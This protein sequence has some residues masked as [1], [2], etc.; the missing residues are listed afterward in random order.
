MRRHVLFFASFVGA[1]AVGA[2]SGCGDPPKSRQEITGEVIL[3]GQP[4][5]DGIINFAPLDGQ[6]S[7][8]GAQIVKGK[9]GIPKEKGLFPGK[10]K[11]TIYAGN[12]ASGQ[13]NASPDP[14]KDGL[15]PLP[16]DRIPP[17]YNTDSNV[18]K[19]V[20]QGGENKFDFNIP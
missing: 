10:Y 2:L 11:V 7:G 18:V 6:G 12:G 19:E 17:E 1:T 16:R 5:E 13:G 9:Y 4:V 15:K 14:P 20:I 3:K 8:D